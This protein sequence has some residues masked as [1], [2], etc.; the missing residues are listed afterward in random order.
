MENRTRDSW[1]CSAV[2]Q[3]TAPP[4]APKRLDR[5]KSVELGMEYL[6]SFMFNIHGPVHR[7]VNQ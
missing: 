2:S 6:L 4:R 5:L 1:T 7:S 3:P